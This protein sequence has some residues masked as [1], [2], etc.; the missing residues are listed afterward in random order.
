[1]TLKDK[2]CDLCTRFDIEFFFEQFRKFPEN[3]TPD[4]NDLSKMMRCQAFP[5]GIPIEI[6]ISEF[7][8]FKKHPDQKNDI[9]FEFD[10]STNPNVLIRLDY[11]KRLA[12]L[13]KK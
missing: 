7:L 1:M 10:N 11:F 8:H 9:V 4:S 13:Q 3:K 12:M 2:L 5:D 6:R